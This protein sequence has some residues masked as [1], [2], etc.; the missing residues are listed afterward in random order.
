MPLY[1]NNL[2]DVYSPGFPKLTPVSDVAVIYDGDSKGLEPLVIMQFIAFR[3]RLAILFNGAQL[4][5]GGTNSGTGTVNGYPCLLNPSRIA[6]AQAA[7]AAAKANGVFDYSLKIGINDLSGVTATQAIV[8]NI[9]KFHETVVRPGGARYLLLW[10]IDPTATISATGSINSLNALYSAYADANSKDVIFLNPYNSILDPTSSTSA[11]IGGA[12]NSATAYSRDGLHLVRRALNAISL[13]PAIDSAIRSIYRQRALL[14]LSLSGGYDATAY[15]YGNF[16]G[17]TGRLTAMGGSGTATGATTVSG[18]PPNGWTLSGN[19]A[20]ASL[21]W[22]VVSGIA[23]L[24]TAAGN[25]GFSAVRLAISGTLTANMD[26]RLQSNAFPDSSG[27]AI[28]IGDKLQT[29]MLVNFN[30]AAGLTGLYLD[31]PAGGGGVTYGSVAGG[32]SNPGDTLPAI[33][34]LVTVQSDPITLASVPGGYG[35][36]FDFSGLNGAVLGGSIDL[37]AVRI[38]K[39]GPIPAVAP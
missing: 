38:G 8:A 20:G 12:T 39:I 15:R 36:G 30:A 10:A 28:A 4:N 21:T 9:R 33:N 26:M 19:A 13:T 23:A 32:P 14:D 24:E 25:T 17:A 6:T 5:L 18:T 29:A 37:F 35:M 16:L 7:C 2:A 34:G 3:N 22:S 11:L 1:S 31:N 27:G